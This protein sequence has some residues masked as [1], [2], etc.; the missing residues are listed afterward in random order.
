MSMRVLSVLEITAYLK[1]LIECDPVLSD[2]WVRGEV[3][4]F[5][6]SAA[7]HIYFSLTSES[8]QISCVLFRGK[9]KGLLAMPRSGE[10]VLVHGRITLYEMRGQYQVMVDNVAPIGIGVMQL[11]FEEVRR[12]L[13]A[14]GLF[15]PDRKRPLPEMPATIGVVT[16]AQGAVWHDIQ[17][18]VARRFPLTELILAPSAVQG[19]DAALDLAR[20]LRKLDAFGGCDIIIIGRG[21]GSAEDLAAFNDE[22]LARAIYAARTPIVSAVGHETDTCI[23]DLVAD[24]RAPTPSAAAELC[25]PDRD[26]IVAQLGFAVMRAQANAISSLQSARQFV[27]QATLSTRHRHPSRSLDSA[28]QVVDEAERAAVA[29]VPRRLTNHRRDIAA[30]AA[31]SAL[32][33]PRAILQ[34]GYALVSTSTPDGSRRVRSAVV[35]AGAG[36]LQIEFADGAVKATVRQERQ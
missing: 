3:T 1:E 17:N 19:P 31:A 36:E 22:G 35:A 6:R 23:A 26:E 7:G 12:R 4:N 29:N 32:L 8:L 16:S 34:R 25:V 24:V 28:R 9:Q 21:G 33:D 2:I 20:A 18:V 10:E 30:L 14:E 15:A 11:Q 27:Q 5:S 13:E